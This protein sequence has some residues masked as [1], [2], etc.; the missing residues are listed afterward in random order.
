MDKDF[1]KYFFQMAILG[2]TMRFLFSDFEIPTKVWGSTKT[3]DNKNIT[4][5]VLRNLVMGLVTKIQ[6]EA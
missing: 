1:V 2:I 5:S 6:N 3:L 4:R